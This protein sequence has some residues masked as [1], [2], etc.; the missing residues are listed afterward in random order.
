M[1]FTYHLLTTGRQWPGDPASLQAAISTQ[2]PFQP[3][4]EIEGETLLVRD[5]A[6]DLRTVA[7]LQPYDPQTY[8]S[9][10][11]QEH[12]TPRMTERDQDTP[13]PFQRII[14]ITTTGDTADAAM[15][16]ALF[17]ATATDG[18]WWLMGGLLV[19]PYRKTVWGWR[20]W[21]GDQPLAAHAAETVTPA[22]PAEGEVAP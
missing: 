1:P 15:T 4:V 9:L 17:H 11:Q 10:V 14:E 2:G 19:D 8:E 20:R 18:I 13:L 16:P 3:V 7:Q 5:P 6:S 22:G 21:R 12:Y